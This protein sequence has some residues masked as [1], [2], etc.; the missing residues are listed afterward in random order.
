MKALEAHGPAASPDDGL[1]A[2][3]QHDFEAGL[4]DLEVEEFEAAER[5]TFGVTRRAAVA[6]LA[7]SKQQ[8]VIGFGDGDKGA[9][10]LLA[11]IERVREWRSRLVASI[12][13]ADTATA[14]L[15]IVAAEVEAALDLADQ[16]PS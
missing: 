10:A 12:A 16:P 14:R 11:A 6:V 13:V 9:D 8:L 7:R 3:G 2:L 15:L 1:A 4:T 5:E